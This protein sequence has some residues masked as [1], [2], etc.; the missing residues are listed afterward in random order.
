MIRLN[1]LVEGESEETFVNQVLRLHLAEVGVMV[2]ARMVTT[3]RNLGRAGRGGVTNYGKIRSDLS[4]WMKEDQGGDVRFST[5]LDRHGLPPGFPGLSGVGVARHRNAYE[6]VVFL[7]KEFSGDI[8]D[9]RFIPYLQLHEFE[10][11]SPNARREAP[12]R[13][14]PQSGRRW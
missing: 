13:S 14:Q 3:S 8:H 11:T 9:H 10:G 5:M 12:A 2:C 1:L 7:E 4:R 6:D